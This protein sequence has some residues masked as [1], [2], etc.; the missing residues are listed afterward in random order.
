MIVIL[1]EQFV[2]FKPLH[3]LHHM[4]EQCVKVLI[5]D[6]LPEVSIRPC[7]EEAR[8]GKHLAGPGQP[9]D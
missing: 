2:N 3:I 8:Q 7:C 4:M 6:V 1:V 5:V 9:E